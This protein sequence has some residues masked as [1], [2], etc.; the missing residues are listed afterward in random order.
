MQFGTQS[1]ATQALGNDSS[2]TLPQKDAAGNDIP[3]PAGQPRL[4]TSLV[5]EEKEF[6]SEVPTSKIK[7]KIGTETVFLYAMKGI[8]LTFRGFFRNLNASVNIDY[9][10][11]GS[12]PASWKIVET[13]N[14][15]RY[16]N[17]QTEEQEN[18]VYVL[19]HQFQERDL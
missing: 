7:C 9:G 16:T 19:D 2:N 17:L 15:S 5:P 18:Q 1:T 6:D 11:G 14:A 8:P 10:A 4:Q 3:G 12:I 13:G